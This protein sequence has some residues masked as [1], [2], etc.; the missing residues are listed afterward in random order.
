MAP[1]AILTPRAQTAS[2]TCR[3]PGRTPCHFPASTAASAAAGF[4]DPKI[5]VGYSE[6]A[7]HYSA[8]V[9]F[10]PRAR[11]GLEIEGERPHPIFPHTRRPHGGP[12]TISRRRSVLLGPGRFD[13]R[14]RSRSRVC[15]WPRLRQR[16]RST[17]AR[18][19]LRT[20]SSAECR[21]RP[22]IRLI[23]PFSPAS[24]HKTLKLVLIC[25]RRFEPWSC[26]LRDRIG[27]RPERFV[28]CRADVTEVAVS[29]FGV[30]EVV[31]VVG[32]GGGQLQSGRPSA[33]VEQF[34]L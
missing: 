28:L 29:A 22:A 27:G 15:W 20:M 17:S 13:R 31:D 4:T 1:N 24:G 25:A 19:S 6:T 14:R 10:T 11:H 5:G 34:D 7:A 16:G 26:E 12:T 32:H 23:V 3:R 2:Q 18:R 33:G 30:V 21:F 8:S 9:R